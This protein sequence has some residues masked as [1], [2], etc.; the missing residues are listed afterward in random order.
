MFIYFFRIDFN[1]IKE[2]GNYDHWKYSAEYS[3]HLSHWP[4]LYNVALAHF[5]VK[6]ST[7]KDIYYVTSVHRTCLFSGYFCCMLKILNHFN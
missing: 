1:I 6:A 7:K 5:D 2:S 3:E 4:Y